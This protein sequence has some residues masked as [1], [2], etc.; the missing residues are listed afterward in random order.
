MSQVLLLNKAELVLKEHLASRGYQATTVTRKLSE[1][2]V[3][4]LTW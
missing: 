4:R 3:L 1:F 2:I